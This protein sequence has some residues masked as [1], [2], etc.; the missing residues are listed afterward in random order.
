MDQPVSPILNRG[1]IMEQPRKPG[2]DHR[3]ERT[4]DD[5]HYHDEDEI[6]PIPDETSPAARAKRRPS[7]PPPRRFE[8]DD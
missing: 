5:P 4:F 3:A 7:L 1:Q 2:P 8:Y 6:A